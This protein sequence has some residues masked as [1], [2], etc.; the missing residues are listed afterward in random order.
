VSTASGDH[1]RRSLVSW[2]LALV[3]HG[4]AIGALFVG[5]R[6]E[7]KVEEGPA[8]EVTLE[9]PPPPEEAPRPEALEPPAPGEVSAPTATPLARNS[10]PSRRVE[11]PVLMTEAP[12]GPS[13][14]ASE[15]WA[16]SVTAPHG[17]NL[18]LDGGIAWRPSLNPGGGEGS[19]DVPPGP[20]PDVG[21]LRT[22]LAEHDR[23]LGFGSGGRIASAVRDADRVIADLRDGAAT[24]QFVTDAAGNVVS[25]RVVDV[26][27]N[28]RGWTEAAEAIRSALR[29]RPLQVP[30]G[31][32]GKVVTVRVEVAMRLPSG[33]RGGVQG[34]LNGDGV[35]GAADLSD[36]GAR[37]RAVA[38][39]RV[40]SEEA[41]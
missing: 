38:K 35:G 20:R 24:M 15:G 30:S 10:A 39:S 40:L 36:I 3:L 12:P 29:Q 31:A 21:G 5:S 6:P 37:P 14:S 28:E 32:R 19:G 13:A 8:V 1:A 4:S 41:L 2:G 34:L 22:G 9:Q 26:T 18:G 7:P 16:F 33:S 11:E 23:E 17:I 27:S 25:V